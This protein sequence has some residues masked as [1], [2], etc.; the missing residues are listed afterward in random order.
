MRATRHTA[1]AGTRQLFI[2]Y[3]VAEAHADAAIAAAQEMQAALTARR[4]GLRA[5][6]LYRPEAADG[7]ITLME[8]Y[9]VDA[10][11][12]PQGVGA[13][14]QAEIEAL[15][16]TRAIRVHVEVFDEC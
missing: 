10:E 7:G 8:T 11:V 14:L 12:A 15:A 6:L 2:Y 1:R 3:R 4:P 5:A 13:A 16:R 9:A